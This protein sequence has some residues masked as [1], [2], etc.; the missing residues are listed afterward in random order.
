[1]TNDSNFNTLASD[2]SVAAT[3]SALKERGYAVVH[4]DTK[5]E[6]LEHIKQVMPKGASVNNGASVT[7]E[8]IGYQEYLAS[9]KHPWDDLKSKVTAE[10]DDAK[11]QQLR[12]QAVFSDFYLGS[13]HALTESG[14]MI[15]ASNTG[16][17]LPPIAF[18]SPNLIFVISTKK[19]VKDIATGMRR[20]E[21]HV[22]P[23][24]DKRMQEAMGAH[25][26]LNKILIFKND[27]SFLGRKIHVI[28]INEDLGF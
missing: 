20:L 16:S 18:T 4:V 10:D 21:E 9:G 14:D 22:V 28:L 1:M 3:R 11:R 5:E 23:L 24:E 6:A 12:Q 27:P 13:V 19:I 8:Q 2:E 17:Q 15:I 7:L 25:T 26:Q